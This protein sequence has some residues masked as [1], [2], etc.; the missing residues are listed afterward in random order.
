MDFDFDA[1]S[2]SRPLFE[3]IESTSPRV[4][5]EA[6]KTL[7]PLYSLK[8]AAGYFGEG[9]AVEPEGWVEVGK[10]RKLDSGMFVAQAKG[11]SMQPG[12]DDGDLLVFKSNPA[13]S[14]QGKILLLQYRGPA[15]PD[16]GGSYTVKVYHSSKIAVPEGEWR[17]QQITL[18]PTNPDYEPIL[19]FPKDQNDFRV[20]AE[21]LFKL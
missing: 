10:R 19:L 8:A 4:K 16:T 3:L 18:S 2:A 21:F 9:A 6:F 12:I 17:N 20:V 13:G 1:Q 15:D 7:L 5:K 14:R 11:H